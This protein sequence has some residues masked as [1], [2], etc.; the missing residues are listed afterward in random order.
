METVEH[1]IPNINKL[2]DEQ[3]KRMSYTELR[4]F[5]KHELG[6]MYGKDEALFQQAYRDLVE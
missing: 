1:T 3:Y 4:R 6:L 2:V 5:V